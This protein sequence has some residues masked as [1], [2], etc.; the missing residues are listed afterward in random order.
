MLF[1]GCFLLFAAG[2]PDKFDNS[3]D[4]N[5]YT[6]SEKDFYERINNFCYNFV[7]DIHLIVAKRLISGG[8]NNLRRRDSTT[9]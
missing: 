4:K 2:I 1:A 5:R 9:G 7:D 6:K 8:G 3:P